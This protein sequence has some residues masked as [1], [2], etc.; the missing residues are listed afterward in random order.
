MGQR[1]SQQEKWGSRDKEFEVAKSQPFNEMAMEICF[2]R[3][4]LWKETI[5]TRYGME[6]FWTSKEAL[7]PYG[8][9]VCRSIRNL[10]PKLINSSKIKIGNGGKTFY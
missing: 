4:S 3:A 1:H 2:S 6:D 9:G 10:W 7:P 8:T 5:N